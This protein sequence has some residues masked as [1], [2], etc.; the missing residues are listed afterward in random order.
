VLKRRLFASL[1]VALSM[2]FIS[3]LIAGQDAGTQQPSNS[4]VSAPILCRVVLRNLGTFDHSTMG[5]IAAR[6]DQLDCRPRV[7][8]PYNQAK[9]D[10]M[11]TALQQMWKEKGI[12]VGVES[13]LTQIPNSHAAILEFIVYKQ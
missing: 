11:K 2:L 8:T 4:S 5:E 7:E 13:R 6:I 9:V 3:L 1:G 12:N 10:H